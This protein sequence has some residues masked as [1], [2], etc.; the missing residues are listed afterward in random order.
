[1]TN[2]GPLIGFR[3]SPLLDDGTLVRTASR[4]PGA[5]GTNE[6]D[7]ARFVARLLEA[8]KGFSD[9]AVERMQFLQSPAHAADMV[10][11]QSGLS[12]SPQL[13]TN[14]II[15]VIRVL[16]HAFEK[17]NQPITAK[18]V[19]TLCPGHGTSCVSCAQGLDSRFL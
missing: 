3:H 5:V 17:T 10:G 6:D 7:R 2:R 9:H 16:S 15:Y 13:V 12:K 4:L 1:M 19:R 14:C 8:Q 18:T 11:S